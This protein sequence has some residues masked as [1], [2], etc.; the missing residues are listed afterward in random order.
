MKALWT[1]F[2]I[3]VTGYI[4]GYGLLG[5]Q[6]EYAAFVYLLLMAMWAVYATE[7][8]YG[9]IDKK[10]AKLKADAKRRSYARL[11][12]KVSGEEI[13][14]YQSRSPRLLKAGE[15]LKGFEQLLNSGFMKEV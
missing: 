15:R 8:T 11:R 5:A 3:T 7:V 10:A 4:F 9:K 2:L 14:K 12:R 13:M 1:L 6:P